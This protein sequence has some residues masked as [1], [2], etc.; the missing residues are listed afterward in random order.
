MKNRGTEQSKGV[1]PTKTIERGLV[2]ALM[3]GHELALDLFCI[4]RPAILSLWS[5]GSTAARG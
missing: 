1:D 5:S 4:P 2:Y 3:E